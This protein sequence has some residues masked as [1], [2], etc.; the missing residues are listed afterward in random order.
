MIVMGDLTDTHSYLE[1]KTLYL[2]DLETARALDS[3][4][5]KQGKFK[6]T[7]NSGN[8]YTPVRVRIGH[9]TGNPTWPYQVLGYTNPFLERTYESIFYLEPGTTYL[10]RD[11]AVGPHGLA[12][13]GLRFVDVRPQTA[14]AFKHLRFSSRPMRSQSPEEYNRSL[15]RRY[16]YS[17]YLLNTL[18]ESKYYLSP[19]EV[20]ELLSLFDERLHT[21]SVYQDLQA[22][23]TYIKS[24]TDFPTDVVLKKADNSLTSAIIDPAKYNLVVF[25][26]SWCGPCRREIPQIKALY[27]V[28]KDKLAISSISIDK[29][30]DHWHRALQQEAMP[31]SQYLVNQDI[32]FARL[33]RKYKL[34]AVPLW[35]LFNSKNKLLDY[36][37]GMNE[38]K[39]AIDKRVSAM[40]SK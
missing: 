27:N 3:S 12:K 30:E 20:T 36:G 23:T 19:S 31:W 1:G 29:R 10:E 40:I 9:E 21:L 32:S 18:N 26:A 22:Y 25:W 5:V 33:D 8:D 4:V 15:V 14:V 35:L 16:P 7:V 34:N 13:L 6:F 11:P 17:V 39:D 28:H 24:D 38:G 2:E 37:L